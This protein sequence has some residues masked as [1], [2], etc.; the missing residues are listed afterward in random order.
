[1]WGRDKKKQVVIVPEKCL[2]DLEFSKE[3]FEV[4][5]TYLTYVFSD[6]RKLK[7]R[8]YGSVSQNAMHGNDGDERAPLATEPMVTDPEISSSL[9]NAKNAMLNSYY[10]RENNNAAICDDHKNPKRTVI[11]KVVEIKL[12]KSMPYKDTFNVAKLVL[13]NKNENKI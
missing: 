11:G 10:Y 5:V 9:K 3:T 4:G 8:V 13:R 6:G 2:Y 1:M 7:A 12:G